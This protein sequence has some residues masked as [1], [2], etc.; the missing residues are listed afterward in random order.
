ML[1]NDEEMEGLNLLENFR[2]LCLSYGI[3]QRFFAFDDL[4]SL[5]GLLPKMVSVMN[6]L[7]SMISFD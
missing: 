3:R 7:V 2:T 6:K 5:T 4:P 1:T